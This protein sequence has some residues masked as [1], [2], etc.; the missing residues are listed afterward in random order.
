[1]EVVEIARL[2][3]T[4]SH[5]VLLFPAGHTVWREGDIGNNMYFINSGRIEVTTQA[6][7]RAIGEQGS[8]FGEGK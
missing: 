2:N 1:M 8:F 5:T 7:F 6:G 3:A 4:I